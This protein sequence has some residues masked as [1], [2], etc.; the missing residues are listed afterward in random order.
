MKLCDQEQR[1]LLR[2]KV[3]SADIFSDDAEDE[4]LNGRHPDDQKRQAGPSG[5]GAMN[6][7]AE[8]SVGP[9]C[10][11]Y[12]CEQR[13]KVGRD[14][15]GQHRKTDNRVY[16]EIQQ[17]AECVSGG[18]SKARLAVVEKGNLPEAKP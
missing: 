18:T 5:H 2:L 1:S 13:A 14:P 7:P 16:R 9:D 4:E 11:Q 15:E 12:H 3:N 6:Q 8:K 17:L 10:T